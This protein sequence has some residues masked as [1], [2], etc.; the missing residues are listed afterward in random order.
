M[1]EAIIQTWSGDAC[2]IQPISPGACDMAPGRHVK[3][4]GR[5]SRQQRARRTTRWTHPTSR[6]ALPTNVCRVWSASRV[7]CAPGVVV[8]P[9]QAQR[10]LEAGL[11]AV[12]VLGRAVLMA[13]ER[14]CVRVARVQ[15]QRALEIAQRRLVLLRSQNRRGRQVRRK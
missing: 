9:V 4:Q 15:L 6:Q 2:S 12:K 7:A 1:R 8:A 10:R 14:V 5:I 13:R 3:Q 11:G